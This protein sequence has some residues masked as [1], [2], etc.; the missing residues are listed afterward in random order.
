MS[1]HVHSTRDVKRNDL[2]SLAT[3]QHFCT[4]GISFFPSFSLNFHF[5]HPNTTSSFHWPDFIQSG[6]SVITSQ[7]IWDV[8]SLPSGDLAPLYMIKFCGDSSDILY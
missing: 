1:T 2:L 5:T 4:Y 6:S 8:S 7:T 3:Q